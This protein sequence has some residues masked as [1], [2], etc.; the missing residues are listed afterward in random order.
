LSVAIPGL[1]ESKSGLSKDNVVT[2]SVTRHVDV[3]GF[4]ALYPF[5]GKYPKNSF[6]PHFT[7]GLPFAGQPLHRSFVGASEKLPWI[8]K[9]VGIPV[10]VFGGVAFLQEQLSTLAVGTK[11]ADTA[12]FTNSL[13]RHWVRKGMFGLEVPVSALVGKIG[14][15]K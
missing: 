14:K 10:N 6:A 3:Y 9:A 7:A 8:E 2:A 1:R 12:T 11:A 15:S 5:A 4:L 13:H